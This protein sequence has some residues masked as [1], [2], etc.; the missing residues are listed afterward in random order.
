M[1]RLPSQNWFEVHSEADGVIVREWLMAK[2]SAFL[3][4]AIAVFTFVTRFVA[5]LATRRYDGMR[6][7]FGTF[8][9]APPRRPRIAMRWASWIFAYPVIRRSNCLPIH[10][11]AELHDLGGRL[12]EAVGLGA[13]SAERPDL[14]ASHEPDSTSQ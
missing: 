11:A 14:E 2:A 5:A 8:A 9:S 1:V 12:R 10:S 7:G 6:A 13:T 3:V 4:M